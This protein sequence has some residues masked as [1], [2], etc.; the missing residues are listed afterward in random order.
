[1]VHFMT[2]RLMEAYF[3]SPLLRWPISTWMPSTR[4][5]SP[6]RSPLHHAL[7][8]DPTLAEHASRLHHGRGCWL[9]Y[10]VF[11]EGV[12]W[13][14]FGELKVSDLRGRSRSGGG[15]V[16]MDELSRCWLDRQHLQAASWR[17]QVKALSGHLSAHHAT[18]LSNALFTSIINHLPT[19]TYGRSHDLLIRGTI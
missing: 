10:C 5:I 15:G 9:C 19:E 16:S 11:R 14:I 7:I 8:D 3:T 17:R 13:N 1:M 18:V 12:W 6:A 4:S 2:L